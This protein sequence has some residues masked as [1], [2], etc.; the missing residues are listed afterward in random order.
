[1]HGSGFVVSGSAMRWPAFFSLFQT[2]RSF[3]ILL[4]RLACGR[5]QA[6]ISGHYESGN[7]VAI[8]GPSG[9]G[10]STLLDPWSHLIGHETNDA[11][12]L[13]WCIQSKPEDAFGSH[14]TSMSFCI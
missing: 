1:M 7:L 13:E 8:M 3:V 9:C 2:V 6:P 4:P 11:Y 14:G 10:K 5:F 12:V